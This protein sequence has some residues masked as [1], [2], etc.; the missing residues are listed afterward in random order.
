MEVSISGTCDS[1]ERAEEGGVYYYLRI[2]HRLETLV[3]RGTVISL[4]SHGEKEVACVCA[5]S[6]SLTVSDAVDWSPPGSPV[7][8]ILQAR[9]LEWAAISSSRG[10]SQPGDPNCGSCVFL[11]WQADSSPLCHLGSPRKR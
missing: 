11:H 6:L 2:Y 5:L 3:Q 8:G 4:R 1:K 10:P 7:H 9:M